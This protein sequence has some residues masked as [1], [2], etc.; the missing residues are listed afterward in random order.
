[1][2]ELNSLNLEN[3]LRNKPS[4]QIHYVIIGPTSA[5]KTT[6]INKCCMI[7]K[8][9]LGKTGIGETTTK[10]QMFCNMR[11][12]NEDIYIWDCPGNNDE[13]CYDEV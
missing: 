3:P 9:L 7:P 1:M 6:I 11:N 10:V 12:Q 5:G 13:V 4:N 2:K 8:H